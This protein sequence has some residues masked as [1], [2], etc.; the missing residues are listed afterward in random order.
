MGTRGVYGFRFEDEDKVTY[1]QFDSYPT[2]LGQ[3]MMNFVLSMT[4]KKMVNLFKKIKM[5]DEEQK[6]TEKDLEYFLD[7]W[8]YVKANDEDTYN[9]NE[10]F[11][12]DNRHKEELY[13][14]LRPL[15]LNLDL[16]QKFPAMIDSQRFLGDSLFCEW[17]Y[18]VNLDEG[19]LE[20]YKG[21]NKDGTEDIKYRGRYVNM[22]EPHISYDDTIYYGVEKIGDLH[23]D[24]KKEIG[25]DKDLTKIKDIESFCEGI[26]FGV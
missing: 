25:Y 9:I 8:D 3:K 4:P 26:G 17:A 2:Y 23:F 7:M 22:F 15:Q 6:P 19:K 24:P 5:Y 18:I 21:F 16:L 11:L 1:T 13:A 20:C 10:T 12:Q 14:L